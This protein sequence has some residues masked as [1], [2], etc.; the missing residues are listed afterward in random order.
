MIRKRAA[1]RK[2]TFTSRPMKSPST[3]IRRHNF[4][5]GTRWI[6]NKVRNIA[7]FHCNGNYSHI[8]HSEW[9][10]AI[11]DF[12]T[13]QILCWWLV[14]GEI[15]QSWSKISTFGALGRKTNY[16]QINRVFVRPYK[17]NNSSRKGGDWNSTKNSFSLTNVPPRAANSA[18]CYKHVWR[19][20]KRKGKELYLSVLSSSAGALIMGTVSW[21]QQLKQIKSNAAFEE[22]GK[23]EYPEKILSVQS[24]ESTNSTHILTD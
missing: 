3:L 13:V 8:H 10:T 11:R 22:R 12:L 7:F 14:N 18:K 1:C 15:S 4:S 6:S 9:Q 19:Q 21:N 16:P 17:I 2:Q 20:K 23:L 24:R 5:S